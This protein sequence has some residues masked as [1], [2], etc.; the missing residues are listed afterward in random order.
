MVSTKGE[1]QR[2][3]DYGGQYF[4][5]SLGISQGTEHGIRVLQGGDIVYSNQGKSDVVYQGTCGLTDIKASYVIDSGGDN[6]SIV[7]EGKEYSMQRE[8]I[9]IVVVDNN[10]RDVL[11]CVNFSIQNGELVLTR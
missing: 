11:A 3:E 8:G 7:V 4:L 10:Y 6:S 5:D 1:I 9:N 2:P